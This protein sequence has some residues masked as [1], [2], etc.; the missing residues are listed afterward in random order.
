[1]VSAVVRTANAV[2]AVVGDVDTKAVRKRVAELFGKYPASEPTPPPHMP[3][4][5]QLG[6]RRV[7]LEGAG[8][9]SYFE[10]VYRAPAAGSPDFPAFVLMQELLGGSDGVN[11]DQGLSGAP[12]RDGSLLKGVAEEMETWLPPA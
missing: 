12:V 1:L 5:P 3:E 8:D 10:I 4:S 9:A 2:L 11:F 7:N 6:E